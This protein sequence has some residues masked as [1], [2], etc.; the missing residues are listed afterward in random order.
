[1][2]IL[3][4]FTKALFQ[5]EI[6]DQALKQKQSGREKVPVEAYNISFR[7]FLAPQG[8]INLEILG[9]DNYGFYF[10]PIGYYDFDYQDNLKEIYLLKELEETYENIKSNLENKYTSL[11]KH[12]S[13]KENAYIALGSRE[14]SNEVK[15]MY[16][17]PDYDISN[18]LF[19]E[20]YQ[21]SKI[22]SNG[23]KILIIT[24]MMGAF[25]A[26]LDD[27]RYELDDDI[28]VM[29]Q[30][31]Y[32]GIGIHTQDPLFFELL[33]ERSLLSAFK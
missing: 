27:D 10:K 32:D 9:R 2:E 12:L 15:K 26:R 13:L 21:K 19:I 6:I 22:I 17:S 24:S 14:T 7:L 23:L 31:D 3:K 11:A 28:F 5:K 4:D 8:N 29:F 33:N 16:N 1:M 30:K 20:Q 18:H 25:E